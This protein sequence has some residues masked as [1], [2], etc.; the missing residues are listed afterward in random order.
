MGQTAATSII[1]RMCEIAQ[2]HVRGK[3]D[4]AINATKYPA[5]VPSAIR[6]AAVRR[7]AL[8]RRLAQIERVF[9][10]AG[11]SVEHDGEIVM[12][13]TKRNRD[14]TAIRAV[15]QE[16]YRQLQE[17]RNRAEVDCLPMGKSEV[18]LRLLAFEKELQALVG[19]A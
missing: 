16:K 7:R 9:T 15:T 19:S 12:A 14:E 6:R 18:A 2:G 13:Y 5:S 17:A 8:Q 3:C 4:K 11:L 10:D 1:R